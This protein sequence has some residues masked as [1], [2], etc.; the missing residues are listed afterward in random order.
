MPEGFSYDEDDYPVDPRLLLGCSLV[1]SR[2]R[3][4][5]VLPG[6][7]HPMMTSRGGGEGYIFTARRVLPVEGKVEAR[8]KF[9]KKRKI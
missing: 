8:G 3:Q 4:W 5:Q 9:T 1:T 7:T 2:A 6:R